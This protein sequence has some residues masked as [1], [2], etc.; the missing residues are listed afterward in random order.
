MRIPVPAQVRAAAKD[1]IMDLL[2]VSPGGEIERAVR[3]NKAFYFA[4]LWYWKLGDGVLTSYPIV[5]ITEGP[6]P[7]QYKLLIKELEEEGKIAVSRRPV[8]PYTADVFTLIEHRKVDGD[9]ARVESIRRAV[10]YCNEH[11]ATQL[12]DMIHEWSKSWQNT[13]Q[14]YEMDIYADLLSDMEQ[15]E[16]AQAIEAFGQKG[17]AH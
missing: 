4:H 1:L 2:A 11:S 15:N 16:I 8:G 6:V 14:G 3:L 17:P 7:D 12:S 10:E 9:P 13:A 5:R